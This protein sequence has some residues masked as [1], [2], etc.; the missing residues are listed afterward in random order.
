MKS[1]IKQ[2]FIDKLGVEESDLTDDATHND[3]GMDSLD[4]VDIVQEIE[5]NLNINISDSEFDEL[6]Q[7]SDYV[8][9]VERKI[10]E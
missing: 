9:M 7:F 6:K 8:A 3:L 2:I 5:R 1:Q 10:N 4:K